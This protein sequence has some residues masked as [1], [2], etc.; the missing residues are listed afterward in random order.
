MIETGKLIDRKQLE[1]EDQSLYD[2]LNE[3]ANEEIKS[4]SKE[5]EELKKKFPDIKYSTVVD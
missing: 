5:V 1:K 4:V 2:L 3:R